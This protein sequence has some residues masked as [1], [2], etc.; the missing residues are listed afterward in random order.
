M[1]VIH[2]KERNRRI[3]SLAIWAWLVG[4][5][6]LLWAFIALP[7][8]YAVLILLGTATIMAIL[9][10]VATAISAELAD[11]QRSL[12]LDHLT[13]RKFAE[14]M[15]QENG[16]GE[17]SIEINWEAARKYAVDDVKNVY[18]NEF[19]E[20][21]FW[22]FTWHFVFVQLFRLLGVGL[23]IAVYSLLSNLVK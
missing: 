13:S 16:I 22:S 2:L 12:W 20:P 19:D 9:R 3:L 11:L 18:L 15:M 21:G 23:G 1:T 4:C 14:L 7:T 17:E 10:V 8:N 6:F 5:I